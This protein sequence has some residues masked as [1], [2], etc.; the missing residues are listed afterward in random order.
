MAHDYS[1]L[2]ALE[3]RLSHERAF[4]AAERLPHRAVLRRIWISQ[5]E[6]EIAREKLL[7]GVVAVDQ[8]EMTDD[9]LLA[10]LKA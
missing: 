10:A 9:E 2:N 8:G 7:L 4:L 1:H 3:V 6:N 5:V